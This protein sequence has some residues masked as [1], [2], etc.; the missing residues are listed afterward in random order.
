MWLPKQQII[1]KVKGGGRVEHTFSLASRQKG[2]YSI[3]TCLSVIYVPSTALESMR[4]KKVT[5]YTIAA[6]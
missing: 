3:N 5:R 1:K 6:Q 2:A 4:D